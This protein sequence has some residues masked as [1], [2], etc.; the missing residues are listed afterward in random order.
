MANIFRV[1]LAVAGLSY[2]ADGFV[3]GLVAD[4]STSVGQFT[5]VSEV[6]FIWLLT[7]GRRITSGPIAAEGK[8]PPGSSRSACAEASV[9]G[10]H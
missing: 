9:S 6:A 5:F 3:V 10:T 8:R 7:K 4:P 1:L 2:I